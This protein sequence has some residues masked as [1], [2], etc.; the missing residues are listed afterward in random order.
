MP[1]KNNLL[2][3]GLT[4]N[5]SFAAGALLLSLRRHSPALFDNVLLFHDGKL[6]QGDADI[7]QSLG[8]ELRLYDTRLPGMDGTEESA[9]G[10]GQNILQRFSPLAFSRLEA[11]NLLDE[12][13]KILWL[14]VD[15]AI[16][17]DLTPLME[18]GPLALSRE[19]PYFR[20]DGKTAK[21]GAN[22]DTQVNGFDPLAP[23]LN[24]GVIVFD[25]NLPEPRKLYKLCFKWL[26]TFAANITFADQ[27]LFNML[28]QHLGKRH[29]GSFT[30]FPY[31]RFNAHPRNP[32]A[33]SAALVH[34]FGPYKLW[35]DGRILALF[36]EWLRD[37][38][39]WRDFG[40]SAWP[41]E[42]RHA[43]YYLKGP[44]HLLGQLPS[45]SPEE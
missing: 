27:F 11:L 5:L 32:L 31:E 41:A 12:Y 35:S 3:L 28:A 19:D 8:A 10:I 39:R 13:R 6:P 44:F 45:V 42:P 33:Q 43:E 16:Q 20:H 40:G 22:I 1:K 17:G 24:S 21:A 7:L 38:Q 36:P 23:N 2:L 34:G 29:P 25:D 18:Y 37:Y 14:D 30:A 26:H 4:G 9:P 15:T